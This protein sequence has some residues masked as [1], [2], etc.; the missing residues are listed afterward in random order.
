MAIRLLLNLA[1]FAAIGATYSVLA[2]RAA[3]RFGLRVLLLAWP[4][5]SLLLIVFYAV[6]QSPPPGVLSTHANAI[7]MFAI[8]LAFG[9]S[10][11]TV[12]NHLIRLDAKLS[13]RIIAGATGAFFLGF[14]LGLLPLLMLDILAFARRT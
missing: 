14:I 10:T 8:F 11:R 9:L 1:I 5:A 4:A 2:W 6:A 7:G 13:P 3:Q 12:R